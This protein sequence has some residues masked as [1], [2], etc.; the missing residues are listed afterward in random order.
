ML[1]EIEK[2]P[3]KVGYFRHMLPAKVRPKRKRQFKP[4]ANNVRAVGGISVV[5]KDN[6]VQVW[7]A[8]FLKFCQPMEPSKSHPAKP[9]NESAAHGFPCGVI[10][11]QQLDRQREGKTDAAQL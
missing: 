1:A 6:A 11:W 10:F 2:P 5:K 8:A 9:P 7:D 4:M 3:I